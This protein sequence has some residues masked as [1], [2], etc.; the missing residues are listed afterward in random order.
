LVETWLSNKFAD[1]EVSFPGYIVYRQDRSLL[2][3]NKARG[4]GVLIACHE[5]L[6]S[7][8]IVSDCVNMEQIFIN[9]C[10][11][12]D[13]LIFGV[14]YLPPGSDLDLYIQHCTSLEQ[15]TFQFPDHHIVMMGDYNLPD[16]VWCNDDLGAVVR[17]SQASSANTVC[18]SFSFLNLFQCNSVPNDHNIFLDL[19]FSSFA[20]LK[21]ERANDPLFPNNYHHIAYEFDVTLNSI[22]T[23]TENVVS[24]HDFKNCDLDELNEYFASC[25]WDLVYQ[26]DDIDSAVQMFYEIVYLGINLFVP[27]KYVKCKFKFPIWF[28]IELKNLIIQKKIAHMLFKSS[29]DPYDYLQFSQLRD[30]CR[31]CRQTCYNVYT[32]NMVHELPTNPKKFWTHIN[33]L[34]KSYTFPNQ[35]YLSESVGN[36]SG[37]VSNLFAEYFSTVY[38]NDVVQTLPDYTDSVINCDSF[39]VLELDIA[40][41]YESISRLPSR[42]S[43]GPD[44]IPPILIKHCV[45]TLSLP[46]HYL[47]NKSLSSGIFPSYWKNSYIN[48]I[49]KSGDRSDIK[50]YRGICIQCCIPKL[51]DGLVSDHL[52]RHAGSCIIPEQHGFTPRRSTLSNL[53]TYQT[54]ILQAFESRLQVDSIYTD[55]AKAFDRVNHTLLIEKLNVMGFGGMVLEWLRSFL[56][57]R[58]QCVRI[59]GSVSKEIC[60]PSGVPQ[61][62]HIGPILF[63]LFINDIGHYIVN[64]DILVY[65]DDIKILRTISCNDDVALLQSDLDGL[66]VWADVNML[67]LNV[68][69]CFC[70]TF[71]RIF[72]LIDSSYTIMDRTLN[73]CGSIKDLGVI[74]DSKLDFREHVISIVN[75]G[76]KNLGFI[77]R[78]SRDLSYLALP[79]LYYAF[80]RSGLEYC[81]PVWSP[82]YACHIQSVESVQRKFAY[83]FWLRSDSRNLFESGS[84]NLVLSKLNIMDLH[85]RR[86]FFDL[87]FLHRLINGSIDSPQLLSNVKFNT[88][89]RT[90][91]TH[92]FFVDLHCCNY[93]FYS[94]FTRIPRLY[95]EH[96]G[97]LDIFNDSIGVFRSKLKK[98]L[99]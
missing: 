9:V 67:E 76:L 56:C 16:A 43:Y 39:N 45:N 73:K 60:V 28:S 23:Y 46:I 3:S 41:V 38:R 21:V 91:N 29:G 65:A 1:S 80:V 24:Y 94:P 95:N 70:I 81:T 77:F 34:K 64:S 68:E 99:Q 18:D 48:P 15:I 88:F 13:Q 83:Y 20:D 84:Y 22:S 37:E 89:F 10:Q 75:R 93:G 58:S 86:E 33:S 85:H 44:G 47:F 26:C 49:F 57:G 63:N 97:R 7:S 69:K 12:N 72:N 55:F 4:G 2:T 11:G 14:V 79:Y 92:L 90:R 31:V 59:G 32:S 82:Y 98:I 6:T 66:L 25:N 61:G 8:V 50:N 30:A 5:S 53:L 62:S 17:C 52:K 36:G 78:S 96:Q 51:L 42:F 54:K 74:M 40:E 35:M 87:C 71:A 19:I 27:V